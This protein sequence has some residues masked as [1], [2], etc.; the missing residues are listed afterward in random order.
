MANETG[1]SSRMAVRCWF[2]SS[3]D[4]YY[5]SYRPSASIERGSHLAAGAPGAGLLEGL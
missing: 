2:L 3:C 4:R 1:A 5:S